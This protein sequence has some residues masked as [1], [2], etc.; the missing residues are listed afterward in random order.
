[1]HRADSLMPADDVRDVLAQMRAEAAQTQEHL[2]EMAAHL[3]R[4]YSALIDEGFDEEDALRLVRDMFDYT[5]RANSQAS[6][7]E[8]FLR[9]LMEDH[10][11]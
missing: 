5:V 8:E 11:E 9:R 2:K 4:F 6:I 3:W 1:M 7:V 10:G